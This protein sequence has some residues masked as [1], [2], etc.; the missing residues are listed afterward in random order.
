MAYNGICFWF[1]SYPHPY[2]VAFTIVLAL[3]IIGLILTGISRPSLASLVSISVPDGK[4]KYDLADFIE[5]PGFVILIRVLIDYNFESFYRII[6]VGTVGFIILLVLLGVTHR[7]VENSNKNKWIIYLK[8]VGNIAIYS[9][10]ATYGVNC[11]Y[12]G[13]EAKVYHTV[14]TNQSAM[15]VIIRRII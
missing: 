7:L 9:Y 14:S 13:S 11:V 15:D 5:V 6:K 4:N 1:L 12:D 8:V 10:A 3:P 2:K